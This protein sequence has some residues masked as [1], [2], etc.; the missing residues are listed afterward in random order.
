[1]EDKVLNEGADDTD[2]LSDTEGCWDGCELGLEETDGTKDGRELGCEDGIDVG[3]SD[4]EGC[5]LGWSLGAADIRY[6]PTGKAGI[7]S[8]FLT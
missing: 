1:M 5:S 4:T 2:G 7:I 3:Q 6:A 8:L